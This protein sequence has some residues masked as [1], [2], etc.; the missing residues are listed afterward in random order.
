MNG[1]TYFYVVS[2]VNA[3]GEG[4]RSNELFKR[5]ISAPG[6]PTLTAATAGDD[7]VALAWTAPA[8]D[9]GDPITSYKVYRSTPSSPEAVLVTLGDVTEL[10][11][12]D[13][14]R[15]RPSTPTASAP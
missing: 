7:S 1:T 13:G 2:A 10:H 6:A 9:G 12:L 4:P 14:G 11:R 5:P 3:A 15:R 8:S